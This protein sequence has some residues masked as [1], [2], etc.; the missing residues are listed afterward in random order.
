MGDGPQGTQLGLV[1]R[2][3]IQRVLSQQGKLRFL[4]SEHFSQVIM[5]CHLQ[6]HR[7]VICWTLHYQVS[8][9]SQSTLPLGTDDAHSGGDISSLNLHHDQVSPTATAAQKAQVSV[10]K[11]L[12]KA[13]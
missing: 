3:V 2:A 8:I 12:L 10:T 7:A 5:N 9:H 4:G 11:Q 6:P 13:T 1:K